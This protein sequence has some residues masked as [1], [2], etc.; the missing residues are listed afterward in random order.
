LFLAQ[1]APP[2]C[3]ACGA[4]TVLVGDELLRAFPAVFET[5]YRCRA[6]F[7]LTVRCRAV[8]PLE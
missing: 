4:V 7:E 6:C 3:P 8:G 1:P 2:A 5:V